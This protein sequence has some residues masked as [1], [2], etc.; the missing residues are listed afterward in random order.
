MIIKNFA[1]FV[2][3]VSAAI[4]SFAQ[5]SQ[6]EPKIVG[7]LK[8]VKGLI[9]VNIGSQWINAFS[10]AALVVGTRVVSSSSGSVTLAFDNG[11]NIK[12]KANE[13]IVVEDNANCA[14][15]LGTVAVVLPPVAVP[16]VAPVAAM[17]PSIIPLAVL[18]GVLSL[19]AVLDSQSST[20]LS[21][22]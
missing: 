21:G 14:A 13:S 10:G 22:S 1:V 19:R 18:G 20:K 16:V 17:A 2:L 15:L 11:C 8:D 5:R 4:S 3:A 9:S 7:K 6:T 12:L